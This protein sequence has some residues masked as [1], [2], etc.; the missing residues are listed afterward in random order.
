M[1]VCVCGGVILRLSF[2]VHMRLHLRV[3]TRVTLYTHNIH[4][5]SPSVIYYSYLSSLI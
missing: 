3:C 2:S 5:G 1:C 4:L